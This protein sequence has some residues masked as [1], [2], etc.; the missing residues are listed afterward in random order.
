MCSLRERR[1][2][3]HAVDDEPPAEVALHQ[4]TDGVLPDEARARADAAL[5]PKAHRAGPCADGADRHRARR[6]CGDR[7][8][9]VL[10]ANG[11]RADVRQSR[12]VRFAYDDVG[13]AHRFIARQRE[14]PIEHAVRDAVH[15]QCRRQRDRAL[16]LAQLIELRCA[17]SFAKA[18]LHGERRRQ[19]A[20]EWI[21]G[22]GQDHRD[23]GVEPRS[24]AHRG[25]PN[26]DTRDIG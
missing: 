21:A 6:R 2:H 17:N 13:G 18:I 10:G 8:G 4:H 25:V 23:A 1:V 22:L 11:A 26:A 9:H 12:V 14:Q 19:L 24:V 20:R 7:R 3:R 16:E 5:P 15:V